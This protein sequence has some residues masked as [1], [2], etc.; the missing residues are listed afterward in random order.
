M[1]FFPK[2]VQCLG[3]EREFLQRGDNDRSSVGECLHELPRVF[4]YLLHHA[5][6]MLELIY[7]VLELLIEDPAVSHDDHRIKNLLVRVVVQG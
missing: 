4:V 6:L 5:L 2:L 7:R 1:I 3:D